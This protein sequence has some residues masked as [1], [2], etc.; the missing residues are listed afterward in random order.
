VT[1]Q[2][3]ICPGSSFTSS[4]TTATSDVEGGG[5]PGEGSAD[6][7]TT[8]RTTTA[9]TTGDNVSNAELAVT[10]SHSDRPRRAAKFN[11][12]SIHSMFVR[13][14]LRVSGCFTG[15]LRPDVN[16]KLIIIIIII[17]III[18]IVIIIIIIYSFI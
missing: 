11:S 8:A 6:V 15:W 4:P 1:K 16:N 18:I 14:L 13:P 7:E 12:F 9:E 3:I 10:V 2:K 17:N 5:G